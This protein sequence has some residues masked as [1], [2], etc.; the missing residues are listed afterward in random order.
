MNTQ[1]WAERE[2]PVQPSSLC[3]CLSLWGSISQ[4][5]CVLQRVTQLLAARGALPAVGAPPSLLQASSPCSLGESL[6][7]EDKDKKALMRKHRLEG[8]KLCPA[9]LEAVTHI[10]TVPGNTCHTTLKTHQGPRLLA[11]S[12]SLVS[13][14]CRCLCSGKHLVASASEGP[15]GRRVRVWESFLRSEEDLQRA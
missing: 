9:S 4:A 13:H 6:G 2:F 8:R 5:Q 11:V 7:L 15:S 1:G 10:D 3:S 14:V 12:V